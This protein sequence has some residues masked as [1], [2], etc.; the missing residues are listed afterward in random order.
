M[1]RQRLT[2]G[3]IRCLRHLARFGQRYPITVPK[4]LRSI[5]MTLVRRDLAEMWYRQTPGQVPA[6]RGPFFSLSTGGGRLAGCF[7]DDRDAVA[8]ASLRSAIK[9]GPR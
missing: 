7:P 1:K 3:Q 2:H 4:D 5:A 9:R 8:P 6:M